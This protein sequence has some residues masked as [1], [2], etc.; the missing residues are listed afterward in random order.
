MGECAFTVGL[1]VVA[2]RDGGAAAVGVVTLA[3][4]VPSAVATPFLAALADR[5]RRDRLLVAVSTVRGAAIGTGGLLLWLDAPQAAVYALAVVATMAFTVFRPAHSALLPS[6][7]TTTSDL[8]SANVVRGILDASGAL[9]GPTLAG[10]M[11]AVADA[12]TLFAAVA[13]LSVVS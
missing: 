8:M 10:V 2:F 3:R 13:A 5:M 6:L 4:M 1:G 12:A 9:L 7:C 11:L